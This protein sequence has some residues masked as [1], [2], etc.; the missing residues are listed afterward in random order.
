MAFGSG[1][2]SCAWSPMGF[3]IT[4][5][6]AAGRDHGDRGRPTWRRNPPLEG[7][8]LGSGRPWRCPGGAQPR[9]PA[10]APG[11]GAC[12]LIPATLLRHGYALAR[13]SIFHGRTDGQAFPRTANEVLEKKRGH[14]RPGR[15]VA[16]TRS[17]SLRGGRSRPFDCHLPIHS[18]L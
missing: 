4:S 9:R 12:N 3:K 13:P 10:V 7:S 17:S 5:L 1:G 16:A 8:A 14:G 15:G 2:L 6:I 18:T 11:S